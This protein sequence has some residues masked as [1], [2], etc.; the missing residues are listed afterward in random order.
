M[1]PAAEPEEFLLAVGCRLS[2]RK[3]R[4]AQA[5]F[6]VF[7]GPLLGTIQAYS[8]GDWVAKNKKETV[9]SRER[10]VESRKIQGWFYY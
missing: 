5:S 9:Q 1:A 3:R 4:A 7:F 8:I 2:A 6:E 10:W